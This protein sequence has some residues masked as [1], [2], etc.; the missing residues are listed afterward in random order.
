MT[1]L[2][3][4]ILAASLFAALAQAPDT[5]A[6]LREEVLRADNSFVAG[7]AYQKYFLHLGKEALKNRMQDA[8]TGIALQAAWEV[9]TKPVRRQKQ[10]EGRPN[11]FYDSAE[12]AK[13]LDF[14]KKRT[15][16]TV[17]DWWA[18]SIVDV[19]LFLGMH[20]SFFKTTEELYQDQP[21][22]HSICVWRRRSWNVP[23][24]LRRR[25]WQMPFSV[26]HVL[27]VQQLRKVGPEVGAVRDMG[28]AR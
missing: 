17:P 15:R 21:S 9:H 2:H 27:L 28:Q 12:L 22:R 4:P 13:F 23:G 16:A 8:D 18:A 5:S 14:L 26:L 11:D 10:V 7:K 19:D 1:S 20:H 3:F 25:D 24:S 6:S